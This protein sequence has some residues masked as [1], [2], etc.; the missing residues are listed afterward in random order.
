MEQDLKAREAVTKDGIPLPDA[1]EALRLFIYTSVG[2]KAFVWGNGATF[3]ITILESAYQSIDEECPWPFRGVMDVRTICRACD[4]YL[5]RDNFP[6][7]GTLHR[8]VDD[9]VHQA[10]YLSAM[11][12]AIREGLKSD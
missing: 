1:L 8:A 9:A 7:T 12:R 4:P 2:K 10:G 5:H 6:M 11:W 3:D